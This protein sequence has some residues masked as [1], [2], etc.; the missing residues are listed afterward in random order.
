[1]ETTIGIDLGTTFSAVATIDEHGRPVILKNS[2]NERLTPSVIY[3]RDGLSMVGDEAKEMQE[4]GEEDVASFFKR[5]MGNSNFALFLN[6]KEYTS[7]MLSTILLKKLKED[8]ELALGKTVEKAVITVPAYFNNFQ[9]EATIRA[10]EKS[11]LKGA[12]YH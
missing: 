10:G 3:F 6:G 11:G 1:M 4:L 12:A 9:R 2:N 8:A 5:D 7:E